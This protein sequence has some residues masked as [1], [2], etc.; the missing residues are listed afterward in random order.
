MTKRS[1]IGTL[2]LILAAAAIWGVVGYRVYHWV[3]PVEAP[4]AKPVLP[5]AKAARPARDS[6]LLNYPDPF[7]EEVRKAKEQAPRTPSMPMPERPMPGIAYKGLI[8]DADGSLKA[9]ITYNNQTDGYRKGETIE[10][11]KIKQI[12]AEC[13]TVRWNGADYTIAAK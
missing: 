6:L 2:L 1:N 9:M 5:K 12:T 7:L 13:I 3:A 11:I 8:R 10:G 4:V